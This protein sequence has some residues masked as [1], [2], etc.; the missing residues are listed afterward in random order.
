MGEFNR[1]MLIL[2]RESRGLSQTKFA[3][4]MGISQA[5]VSKYE[6]GIRVPTPVLVQA[7]ARRLGYTEEFFSLN[8]AMRSFG[9][10]CVYTR[11]RQSTTETKLT[12]LLAEVNVRRI[13]VK[14]LLRA[15]DAH[16]A[17]SFERLDIDEHEGGAAEVARKLR[18]AWN[19]PPGPVQNLVR[20]IEDAGGT[21]IFA[22]FGTSKV[23]ALSQWVAGCPP[24]FLINRTIPTDRMRFSLAHEV[25][26]IVMHRFPTDRME[27]EAD[28]FS[29]EFLLPAAQV[30]PHL[31]AVTLPKLASLKAYWR[32]SMNALLYRAADVG[33][34][35]P[36]R[37]S[38]L[39]MR[40]GQAGYRTHEP[41]EIPPEL[42]ALLTKLL[43]FHEQ[44]LGYG[45]DDLDRV[46]CEPGAFASLRASAQAG[47]L[48]VVK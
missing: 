43:E 35:D 18:V 11:K 7:M 45:P 29:A 39:W 14:Q 47:G 10:G 6:T 38:Y 25:G 24:V 4:E 21:V 16:Y 48:R 8:E 27:K 46:L 37:K 31:S 32:V 12:Q 26:H 42:P 19:L 40:M 17:A 34:I 9:S 20:T 15:V 5:A 13:Q 3:A 33:A 44:S 41:I 2:A 28:D 1:E 30:R 22:D 36:R 23:D